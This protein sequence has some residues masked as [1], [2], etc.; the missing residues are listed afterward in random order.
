MELKNNVY[1]N[2]EIMSSKT[3]ALLISNQIKGSYMFSNSG[4]I[5]CAFQEVEIAFICISQHFQTM[6]RGSKFRYISEHLMIIFQTCWTEPPFGASLCLKCAQSGL[7]WTSFSWLYYIYIHIY[8][9]IFKCSLHDTDLVGWAKICARELASVAS[10]GFPW[11]LTYHH[12]P[13]PPP[14]TTTY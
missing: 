2:M 8:I 3:H 14:T 1:G 10:R 9:Y 13:P 5:V 6:L 11:P 4:K 7:E 12:L